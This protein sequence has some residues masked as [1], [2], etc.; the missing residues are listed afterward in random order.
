MTVLRW[1]LWCVLVMGSLSL[2]GAQMETLSPISVDIKDKARLQRG[3]QLFMNYCLGCHSLKY[4]RYNTMA[5]GIGLTT[6]DGALD[7][8]LLKNNLIFTDATVYDSIENAIPPE[9]A[10]QWFGVVPPDLSLITRSRGADWV[11]HYLKGFY[12]DKKRPF[13]AN[14]VLLP[15]VAMPNILEPLLGNTILIENKQSHTPLLITEQGINVPQTDSMLLDLVTFLAY[16]A[17]PQQL[18]RYKLGV[19]VVGFLSILLLLSYALKKAYWR[20]IYP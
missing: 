4:M 9:D 15:D 10:K 12:Q 8:A 2:F 19:F 20:R 18:I 11:Y 13:G 6:F 7:V 14:N 3:A 17:E 1:C 5:E 16:V